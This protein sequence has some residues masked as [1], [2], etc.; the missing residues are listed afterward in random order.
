[1][2]QPTYHTNLVYL[3]MSFTVA[4]NPAIIPREMFVCFLLCKCGVF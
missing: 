4:E 3:D 2:E 1:M